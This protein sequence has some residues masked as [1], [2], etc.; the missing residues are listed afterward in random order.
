M[1]LEEPNYLILVIFRVH[2][3]RGE[4]QPRDRFFKE[5]SGL[6]VIVVRNDEAFALED[7]A[8]AAAMR[9]GIAHEAMMHAI[10][11]PMEQTIYATGEESDWT[12]GNATGQAFQYHLVC[13]GYE[14]PSWSPPLRL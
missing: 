12:T 13:P 7:H 3:N 4:P 10:D 5:N 9:A 8:V 14:Q 11:E 6:V 2:G 1:L